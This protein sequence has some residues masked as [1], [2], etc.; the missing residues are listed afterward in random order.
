MAYDEGREAKGRK[1]RYTDA[2]LNA[3]INR[4][5]TAA[6]TYDRTERTIARHSGAS[7]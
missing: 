6:Q 7:A 4:E 2:Q 5:I 1:Q 3:I